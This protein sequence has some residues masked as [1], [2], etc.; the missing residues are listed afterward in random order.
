MVGSLPPAAPRK[1]E[2]LLHLAV[3]KPLDLRGC[4]WVSDVDDHHATLGFFAR[5]S[6]LRPIVFTIRLDGELDAS[7]LFFAA[8][9]FFFLQDLFDN[10]G[11]QHGGPPFVTR[12]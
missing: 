2:R 6:D 8:P 10:P 11:I 4:G 5:R 1:R 7:A 12:S 3:K 9:L